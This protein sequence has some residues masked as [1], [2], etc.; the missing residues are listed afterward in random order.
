MTEE[1]KTQEGGNIEA[2]AGL[3]TQRP[4]DAIFINS[5]LKNYDEEP[6]RN[7]FTLPVLG[8]GYIATY[9]KSRGFNVAVLDAED[10]GLGL[11]RVADI[12]NEANPRWVGMNLL[13]PTYAHSVGVLQNIDPK[14]NI[15][16]GGHQAKAMPAQI[17]GNPSLSHIEALVLGE[18]EY[19]VHALLEDTQ[20][21]TELPHVYW[22]NSAGEV[23][24]SQAFLDS[25]S[26]YWLVPD[27]DTLSFVDRVF[28]PQDPF[29]TDRGTIKANIVGSRGC[30][31]DCSFCGAAISANPDITIRTCSK[32]FEKLKKS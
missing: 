26:S 1:I 18:G 14:I 24:R 11:S 32:F 31:Y 25:M 9:A 7:D 19:R 20:R 6:R 28:L 21:R 8:L 4:V 29:T 15:M 16:L 5:P 22:R 12:I 2:L 23:E 10:F 27:I 17:A 30:P 13:A 3:D